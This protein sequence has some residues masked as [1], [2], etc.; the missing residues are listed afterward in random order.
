VVIEAGVALGAGVAAGRSGVNRDDNPHTEV[1][2]AF[3][4]WDD[5]WVKGQGAIASDMGGPK[6]ASLRRQR[7]S[8]GG[9]I[10]ELV[11]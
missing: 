2:A 3:K 9:E 1:P 10:G 6:R 11:K 5:G 4:A 7:R 8:K